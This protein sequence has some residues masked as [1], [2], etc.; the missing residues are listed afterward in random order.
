MFAQKPSHVSDF[1]NLSGRWVVVTGASS[2]IGRATALEIAAAGANLVVH[3]AKSQ[4]GAEEVVSDALNVGVS[5][6]S[7]G[8][9]FR[10]A[11]EIPAFVSQV[12]ERTHGIDAWVHNAGADV[13]TGEAAQWSYGEK[14]AALLDVDL[15]GTM[16]AAREV[17][18]RMKT[19]G[20]G[21]I[22]TVG[23]DQAD[24]GME[25]YSGE[26][27]AA[28]KN[29]IMGYTRS[30]AVSLAP[31][32]RVN[33]IAPGWIKTAW[34]ETASAEWQARVLRETPLQRWGTPEDIAKLARF[35]ISDDAS[36][37]TGQVINVNGGAVR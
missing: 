11:A 36:Y 10:I 1:G 34:G 16:L 26:L 28:T 19:R 30:L 21:A 23:W 2:G 22:L 18:K 4:G 35:L 15:T 3:Y 37:I 13:L 24:R 6:F 31:A 5:S 17:G 9:D 32:V 14:L 20:S 33:C 12:W 25:G 8:C 27:F 7:L 29:A